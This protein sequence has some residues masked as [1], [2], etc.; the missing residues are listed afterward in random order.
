MSFPAVR[1]CS[2]SC[3]VSVAVLAFV[4]PCRQRRLSVPS[5]S[6]AN[7]AA[8][9][10]VVSKTSALLG[11]LAKPVSFGCAPEGAE[12]ASRSGHRAFL[13]PCRVDGEM[14]AAAC[15]GALR[16]RRVTS[17]DFSCGAVS[18][19]VGA[20][21]QGLVPRGFPARVAGQLSCGGG[22]VVRGP[23]LRS[24]SLPSVAGRCAIKPRSAG[25]LERWAAS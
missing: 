20:L 7:V 23:T 5:H 14:K 24:T 8:L 2:F 18:F 22:A 21:S 25:Y 6:A 13:A 1:H 15:R 12:K 17:A 10:A 19:R 3:S 9:P 4:S 11:W 16:G